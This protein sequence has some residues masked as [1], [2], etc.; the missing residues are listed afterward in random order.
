MRA[1]AAALTGALAG[2]VLAV[3]GPAP[4]ASA[5]EFYAVPSSGSWTLDGHG[6]GHG[7]GLSQWG[8]Q[9]AALRGLGAGSILSFYYPGTE[10]RSIGNPV[11]RVQLRATESGDV[12]VDRVGG[13]QMKVTDLATG[14]SRTANAGAYRVVTEAGTQRVLVHDGGDWVEFAIGGSVR[15]S[16]PIA[17]N[18]D[19]GHLVYEADSASGARWTTG[20]EYRGAVQ[21]VR[22]GAT[23]STAVNQVHME[24]YLRSVVPKESPPSFEPAALQAQAVAA[25]SYAWHDVAVTPGANWDTCDTTACQV[26]GGRA[27]LAGGTWKNQEAA[28][29]DDAVASTAG[30]AL[31]YRDSPAFTQF[32]ASNGGARV[33]GS[34]PY[35]A[36]GEDPY[37]GI[38]AGNTNHDWTATLAASDLQARYPQV[39][40]VTGI[41]ITSRTGIGEW[42]GHITGFEVVGSAGTVAASARTGLKSTWWKP[43]PSNEP[44]GDLNKVTV[45]GTSI[46]LEGW[47]VDPDTAQSTEVHVYVDDG[48]GG[49]YLADVP[50]PDVAA[51][52]PGKGDR[53]GFDITLRAAAGMRKICVYAMNLGA[54][55]VNP[56]IACRDVLVGSPPIGNVDSATKVAD[57]LRVAGWAIDPDTPAAPIDVH[58]TVNGKFAAAVTAD[59]SRSDVGRAYPESGPLH[60]YEATVKLSN[61]S[62]AVCAHGIN[63]PEGQG[64]RQLGCRT[65]TLGV[66]PAG[67]VNSVSVLGSQV[68]VTGWALDPDTTAS[69]DAH[70]YVDGRF[71]RAVT[72]DVARSDVGRAFPGYGSAHG[73]ATTL[74]L[75]PGAHQVCVYAINVGGGGRNPLLRCS[76]VSIAAHVPTG[77]LDGAVVTG[78]SIALTGWA[79]DLDRPTASIDVHLYLDGRWAGAV[80]ASGSRRD[81]ASAFPGVGPDHGFTSTLTAAPGNHRVCAYG[82]NVASGN[83]NTLLRCV[84]V[85]VS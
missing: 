56:Q 48:W 85:R 39:G 62:N 33:A 4:A 32:S 73:F 12:R 11:L 61:G 34:Q 7:H 45:S 59:L 27:S 78:S 84:D 16:G 60:G 19:G 35:L 57:Q 53:H 3:A 70:V 44:M 9:G 13:Q 22:T 36:A 1:L 51:V 69:I 55:S 25:R 23:A 83:A 46:R 30:I 54:G 75:T 37:D 64:N 47:T 15:F 26:Y 68:S 18:G 24:D 31:Y 42:G 52:F 67:D 49:A 76:G 2:G 77:N 5:A 21:V 80:T 79:L 38:P 71:T 17:F 20:R 41:R 72:A 63:T 74:T 65:V 29:T 10:Q 81:V 8:A 40:T 58:L 82:I 66:V 6:Y 43:R 14:V 50:R 28:S